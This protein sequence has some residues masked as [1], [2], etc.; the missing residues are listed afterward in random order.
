[1]QVTLSSAS[2][3]IGFQVDLPPIRSSAERDLANA[4]GVAKLA[5]IRNGD[6]EVFLDSKLAPEV[7]DDRGHVSTYDAVDLLR[8]WAGV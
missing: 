2:G 4:I 1:M 8:T 6:G 7:E 5:T 3:N